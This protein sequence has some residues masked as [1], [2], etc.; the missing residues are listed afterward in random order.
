MNRHLSFL[1]VIAV[2]TFGCQKDKQMLSTQ[3]KGN[4]AFTAYENHFLEELWKL[5]PSWAT[6]E[7]YR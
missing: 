5:N 2:F 7:G 1:L 6:E 3:A 4:D